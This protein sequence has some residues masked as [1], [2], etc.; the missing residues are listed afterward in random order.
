MISL[1][2]VK[3][4]HSAVMRIEYIDNL[5]RFSDLYSVISVRGPHVGS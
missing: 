2:D 1:Q 4:G 3:L 5:T